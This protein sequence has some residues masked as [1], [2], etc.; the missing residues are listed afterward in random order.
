MTLSEAPFIHPTAVVDAGAELAEA[1]K[2]WH[3][4]H[5]MPGARIG[6]GSM[7]G[8]GCFVAAS[9]RIGAHVR[10][11]N[12]VSLYD[13]VELEDHVFVGPSAVFTNVLNPRAEIAR[14]AEYRRTLVE[15]GASVGANATLLPGVR[16]GSYAFVG[17]GAVVTHDVLP[18][19]LVVG[20]PARRLGW[21]SRAG[22]RLHFEGEN[23]VCTA[24]GERYR[25][26]AGGVSLLE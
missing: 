13:G 19:E 14:K 1:V 26:F 15:R 5:V 8:Q 12:H 6:R 24:S 17:A 7:L 16:I 25:L 21:M 11:Q 2:I 3:F 10:V 9:V 20:A 22:E 18:F 23:A 4:C